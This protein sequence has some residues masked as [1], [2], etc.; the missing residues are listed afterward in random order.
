M[1]DDR[2]LTD[3]AA[4]DEAATSLAMLKRVDDA[5]S[6]Y[7]RAADRLSQNAEVNYKAAM[8]LRRAGRTDDALVLAQVAAGLGSAPARELVDELRANAQD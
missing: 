1:P 4:V 5:A 2:L 3:P 8:M 6:L 7:L